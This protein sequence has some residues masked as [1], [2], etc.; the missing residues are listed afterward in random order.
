[1]QKPRILVSDCDL[2]RYL[3]PSRRLDVD[4]LVSEFHST[5]ELFATSSESSRSGKSSPPVRGMAS[6]GSSIFRVLGTP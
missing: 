4:R 5:S 1:M 2:T 6:K 3:T